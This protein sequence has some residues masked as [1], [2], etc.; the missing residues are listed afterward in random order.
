[1]K[2]ILNFLLI[3]VTIINPLA[4]FQANASAPVQTKAQVA[5]TA[6][7]QPGLNT[8]YPA[9]ATP[10]PKLRQPQRLPRSPA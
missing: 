10:T 7:A 2:Y 1:M 9:P 6:T 3:L 4:S 5:P 8:G